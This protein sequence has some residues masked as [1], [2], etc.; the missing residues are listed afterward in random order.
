MRLPFFVCCLFAAAAWGQIAMQGP[1]PVYEG[2][3]VAEI[4]LVANPHRDVEPL[5]ALLAQKTGQPYSQQNVEASIKALEG[6]GQFPKVQVSIIPDPNGL[7]LDFLLEPAYFLGMVDFPGT[8]GQF[9][10]TRM[11]QVINL[12][13]EDPYIPARVGIAENVLQRFL[14]RNGFF[15]ASVRSDSQI[16]DTNQLVNVT[17][18]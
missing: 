1:Q 11:L 12:P 10:Y 2:Q 6:T 7:R 13:D 8:Q 18:T 15:Q 5:R 3:N 17:F 9:A 4:D 14:Q 16:D